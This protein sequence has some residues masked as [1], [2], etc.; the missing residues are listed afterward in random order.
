MVSE[1]AVLTC[2][3]N[4]VD[5]PLVGNSL[6]DGV[7]LGDVLDAAGASTGAWGLAV[8][9][10]E[11]TPPGSRLRRPGIRGRWSRT[12]VVRTECR[13][14]TPTAARVRR[15]TWIAGVA[16][17]GVRGISRVEV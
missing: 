5:G 13:I 10:A 15:P 12:A 4:P 8:T 3:S 11:G 7:R 9:C 16:W 6:C 1:Y 2:I 17:A 14:D